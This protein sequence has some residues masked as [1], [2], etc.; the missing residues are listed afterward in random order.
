MFLS[1]VS[2][3][4][5]GSHAENLDISSVVLPGVRCLGAACSGPGLLDFWEM[6]ST[7]SLYS[8]LCLVRW[9][10]HAHAFVYGT[11]GRFFVFFLWTL[12]VPEEYSY[13]I[14]WE[15]I[16]G[17]VVF[18]ASWSDSW[19]MLRPVY[20]SCG[21]CFP[22]TAQCLV[23]SG[24]C[25]ASVMDFAYHGRGFSCHGVE[26]VSHGLDCSA[27]HINSSV[28]LNT[29]IDVPVVQGVQV[30]GV[31][32]VVQRPFP[33]VQTVC[34]TKEIPC[35]WSKCTTSLLCRSCCFPGGGPDVQ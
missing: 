17:Y 8:T 27:D 14:N 21:V 32:V 12:S 3:C 26:A 15:M 35:C 16:S 13:S 20:G 10:I 22:C 29:V 19:Y 30:V 25:Y 9:W 6:A 2:S 11:F 28:L 1:S 18:S 31:T 7:M 24:T 5:R 34:G 23:L 33:M 4:S